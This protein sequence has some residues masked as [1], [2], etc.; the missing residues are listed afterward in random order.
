MLLLLLAG[1]TLHRQRERNV[2][3]DDGGAGRGE[4]GAGTRDKASHHIDNQSILPI[5]S[6]NLRTSGQMC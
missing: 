5:Y 1:P 3:A 6:A 2:S 4:R